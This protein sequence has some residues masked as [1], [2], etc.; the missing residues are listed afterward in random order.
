MEVNTPRSSSSEM[1]SRVSMTLLGA[2]PEGDVGQ[3]VAGARLVGP[4]TEPTGVV[5][6]AVPAVDQRLGEGVGAGE[7]DDEHDCSGRP[8]EHGGDEVT[9]GGR[10]GLGRRRWRSQGQYYWEEEGG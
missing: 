1:N 2:F 5:D 10:G 9:D 7:V 6:H 4:D 8:K 3:A